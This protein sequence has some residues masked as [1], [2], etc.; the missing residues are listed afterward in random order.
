MKNTLYPHLVNKAD[1]WILL[2]AS[3]LSAMHYSYR[4]KLYIEIID[5][6]K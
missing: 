4:F 1:M 2:S 6:E 3:S 5:D